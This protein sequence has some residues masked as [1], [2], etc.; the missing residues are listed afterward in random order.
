MSG[1][2]R[3]PAATDEAANVANASTRGGPAEGTPLGHAGTCAHCGAPYGTGQRFCGSCGQ[4]L[5]DQRPAGDTPATDFPGQGLAQEVGGDEADG[6]PY[7]GAMALGAVLLSIFMPL[8]A[9]IVALILRGQERIQARRRFLKNWAIGSAVWLG[10]GWLLA[11]IALIV[12]GSSVAG[13]GSCQG[14]IDQA[15][16]PTYDSTDGTHWTATYACMNGGT[17][18]KPVPASSVPGGAP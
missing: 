2:W 1:R 8:I 6:P 16:P 10:T 13:A 11:L 17:I 4:G 18:T 3:S 12:I 7:E 5:A 9:L 14:G 15:V